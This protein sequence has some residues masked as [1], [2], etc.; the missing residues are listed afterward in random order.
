M[1]LFTAFILIIISISLISC[2]SYEDS[3]ISTD[4]TKISSDSSLLQ[5]DFATKILDLDDVVHAIKEI[6]G[7]SGGSINLDTTFIDPEGN[8]I[9]I[10][11]ALTIEPNS[12]TGTKNITIIPD[13]SS[14]TISFFPST[15][16]NTP[17][18]LNL[19]FSGINLSRLGFDEDDDVDF[20]YMAD[21]GSI[22]LI[23]KDECKINWGRQELKVK[24]A[25]LPHFS[26][27]G[28]IR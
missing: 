4:L 14:G 28:F 2:E 15:A 19:K 9:S 8:I 3:I 11:A 21:D 27:Y 23:E 17:V 10:Q 5:Y 24:K 1:K 25:Y 6:D 26:R 13:P 22:Q 12:F 20:V 18:K 16:F 7:T